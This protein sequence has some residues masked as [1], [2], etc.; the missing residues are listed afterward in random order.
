MAEFN[1]Y[2]R[3]ALLDAVKARGAQARLSRDSGV[4]TSYIN[5]IVKGRDYGSEATRR[6]LAASLGFPGRSYEDFLDLGRAILNGHKPQSMEAPASASNSENDYFKIP[7]S[8]QIQLAPGSGALLPAEDD[9]ASFLLHGPTVGR[10]NPWG[11]RA[12][13]VN[14]TAMEPIL[15]Q[16][17][18]VV[19]DTKNTDFRKLKNNA[20]YLICFD[21]DETQGYLRKLEWAGR[22][23]DRLA[24]KAG[25]SRH[26]I[27]YRAP[28]EVRI[29]GRILWAWRRFD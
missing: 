5:N 13:G 1:E 14:E 21:L 27:L 24:I 10:K 17:D 7:Y 6:A 16:G 25:N 20:I 4:G 8:A 12:F 3:A 9:S 19:V 2:F 11:L 15:A 18:T 29:L 22:E 28:R 23:Q 26:P